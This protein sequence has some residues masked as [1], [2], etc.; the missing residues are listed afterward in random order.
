MTTEFLHTQKN[1]TATHWVSFGNSSDKI[2]SYTHHRRMARPCHAKPGQARPG[3][4]KPS[5]SS[6]WG[7][8]LV[9]SA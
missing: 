4:A 6:N 7:R 8:R 1:I 5:Q 3:Q 9:W 2:P